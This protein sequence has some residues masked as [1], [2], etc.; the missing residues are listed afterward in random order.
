MYYIVTKIQLYKYNTCIT[1]Y[2]FN[3]G[4]RAVVVA[5]LVERSLPKPEIHG[6]NPINGN[7]IYY[8]L[9]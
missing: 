5:Q 8:H 4:S 2:T 6:S 7:I 1:K 9:Y 3:Y